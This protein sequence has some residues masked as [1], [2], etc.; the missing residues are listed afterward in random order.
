[1]LNVGPSARQTRVSGAR[2]DGRPRCVALWVLSICFVLGS[3]AGTNLTARTIGQK[4][5]E[6]THTLTTNEM[7]SHIHGVTDPGHAHQIYNDDSR[8]G[9]NSGAY[10]ASDRKQSTSWSQAN[11]TGISI[12]STGSGAPHNTLPPYYVLAFIMRVQ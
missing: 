7:P 4:G 12:Q 6:E 3:G 9:W 1:M 5:G 2:P 11:S 8:G 10:Y